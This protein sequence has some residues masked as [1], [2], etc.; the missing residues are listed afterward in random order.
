MGKAKPKIISDVVSRHVDGGVKVVVKA[1]T[2]P[3]EQ[4][5]VLITSIL[6]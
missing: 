2:L 4:L 6:K 3:A 5:A 1:P